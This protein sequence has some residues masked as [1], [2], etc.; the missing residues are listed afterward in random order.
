MQAH[1][2]YTVPGRAWKFAHFFAS[3]KRR[4]LVLSDI[5][6]G[7]GLDC[8]SVLVTDKREARRIA[9]TRGAKCWNF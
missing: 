9:Q 8:E 6:A 5:P 1:G 2:L 4:E 3:G 7:Y